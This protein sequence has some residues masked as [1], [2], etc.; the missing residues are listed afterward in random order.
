MNLKSLFISSILLMFFSCRTSSENEKLENKKELLNNPISIKINVVETYWESNFIEDQLISNNNSEDSLTIKSHSK[1][2]T[3][4]QAS[5]FEG[6]LSRGIKYRV[7]A[8]T[9]TGAYVTHVDATVG[10]TSKL[11][12]LDSGK[13]YTIVAYSFGN[14]HLPIVTKTNINS[15]IWFELGNTSE[16]FM[17]FKKYNFTPIDGEPINIRFTNKISSV[18][19]VLNTT[20]LATFGN[21]GSLVSDVHVKN[22]HYAKGY[23]DVMN[24]NFIISSSSV[25]LKISMDKIMKDVYESGFIPMLIPVSSNGH[26]Y[27]NVLAPAK[28]GNQSKI[29]Q[30]DLELKPG[31]KHTYNINV[32]GESFVPVSKCTDPEA[33]NNGGPL[34]CIYPQ[35]K[36][37]VVSIIG[38]PSLRAYR[39]PSNLSPFD[40]PGRRNRSTFLLIVKIDNFDPNIHR[41]SHDGVYGLFRT[42]RFAKTNSNSWEWA[43]SFQS[44]IEYN[45]PIWNGLSYANYWIRVYDKNT[46]IKLS[47]REIEIPFITQ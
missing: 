5:V 36:P 41:I 44:W 22:A 11:L 38:P 35:K 17:Y 28:N 32:T 40:C 13:T 21:S 4:P 9:P 8:F 15:E 34:P 31:T 23:I 45:S 37:Q 20:R 39:C 7:I 14:K 10:E 42:E 16:Q 46:G 6:H 47:E 29:L 3:N 30:T 33:I 43:I 18:K 12:E 25:D 2:N 19:I 24:G 1:I 27:A 26:L